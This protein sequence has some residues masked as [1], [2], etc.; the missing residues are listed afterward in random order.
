MKSVKIAGIRLVNYLNDGINWKDHKDIILD[1]WIT[2]KCRDFGYNPIK[3]RNMFLVDELPTQAQEDYEAW[4]G[5]WD[6]QNEED[7]N[8]IQFVDGTLNLFYHTTQPTIM[9]DGLWYVYLMKSEVQA[10]EI[11]ETQIFH[12]NPNLNSF[13]RMD[14][15]TKPEE[16]AG[17]RNG[18]LF[19]REL[20]DISPPDTRDFFWAIA[21]QCP[22]TVKLF[23]KDGDDTKSK[24]INWAANAEHMTLLKITDSGRFQVERVF[25]EGKAWRDDRFIPQE[26]T[27]TQPLTGSGLNKYISQNYMQMYGVWDKIDELKKEHNE[28]VNQRKNAL[29]TFN[30]EEVKVRQVLDDIDDFIVRGNVSEKR[31]KQNKAIR[32][33]ARDKNK[34]R[35]RE[36]KKKIREMEKE[37]NKKAR[38]DR[39]S[40]NPLLRKK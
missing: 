22:E 27:P 15:N 39:Q 4:F 25:V 28:Q 5:D 38:R 32:Q 30:D 31:R 26:N 9:E 35:D 24:C 33:A 8:W 13:W 6:F 12:G 37:K 16:V 20:K 23:Y 34:I 14:T 11:A 17:R 29:N 7:E 2:Y 40:L 19:T 10:R 21:F 1:F 36:I 3:F 18:Y